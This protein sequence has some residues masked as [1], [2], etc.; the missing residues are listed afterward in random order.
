MNLDDFKTP[1][2]LSIAMLSQIENISVTRLKRQ[3][4]TMINGG[5]RKQLSL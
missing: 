3:K 1:F 2:L 4:N 5:S